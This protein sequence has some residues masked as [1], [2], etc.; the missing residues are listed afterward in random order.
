MTSKEYMQCVTA[1]EASWL[2]EMAPMFYAVKETMTGNER[3]DKQ[4]TV[5]VMEEQMK[6]AQR[7]IDDRKANSERLARL[8]SIRGIIAEPGS[9]RSTKRRF[10][11]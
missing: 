8:N 3:M 9:S 6:Q 4:K 7:E 2:V 10:G 11:L 1:V 5:E